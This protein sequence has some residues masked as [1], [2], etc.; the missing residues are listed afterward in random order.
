MQIARFL[1]GVLGTNING[2]E[3]RPTLVRWEKAGSP[4]NG[5]NFPGIAFAP[6]LWLSC[7]DFLEVSRCHV[8]NTHRQFCKANDVEMLL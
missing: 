1:P 4:T 2:G 5:N 3:G 7:G 8:H 6:I